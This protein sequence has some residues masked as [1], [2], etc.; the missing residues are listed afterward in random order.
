MFIKTIAIAAIITTGA[1]WNGLAT[2]A[3]FTNGDFSSGFDSWQSQDDFGDY[4]PVISNDNF[5]ASSGK[6]ILTTDYDN[7]GSYEVSLFQTFTVQTLEAVGNTLT[8]DFDISWFL[9]NPDDVVFVQMETTD[10]SNTIYFDPFDSSS[11][12]ITDFAGMEVDL[13]FGLENNLGADD[14]MTIDNIMITQSQS[15]TNSVPEP[16]TLLLMFAGLGV[17]RRKL[18]SSW[19]A[20]ESI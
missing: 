19:V 15:Q 1:T 16:T 7:G 4:N 11:F 9:D 3:S 12:D 20:P 8:L 13:L 14:Y 6:A 17:M 5:N 10:Y 2:A 18:F